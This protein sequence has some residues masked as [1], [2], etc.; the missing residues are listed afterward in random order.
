MWDQ[1]PWGNPGWGALLFLMQ[2]SI[3]RRKKRIENKTL[4]S[5]VFVLFSDHPMNISV[6]MNPL[7]VVRGSSVN[8]TCSSAANPAADKYTWYKRTDARSS[9]LQVGSGQVLSFPSVNASHTGLYLCQA[10]NPMGENRS[11]EV[12]LTVKE[13]GLCYITSKDNHLKWWLRK[14][15]LIFLIYL[16]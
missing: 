4:N 8:L 15:V 1:V 11:A 6:L 12:L 9:M 14:Q 7:H 3:S 2:H 13:N 10:G 5:A 16:W